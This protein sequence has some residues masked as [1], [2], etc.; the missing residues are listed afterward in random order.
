MWVILLLQC[1]QLLQSPWLIPIHLL[2][3][4][5]AKGIV[6]ICRQGAA[7]FIPVVEQL[8]HLFTPRDGRG[9][10]RAI[11][12]IGNRKVTTANLAKASEVNSLQGT[13]RGGGGKE[14]GK[15]PRT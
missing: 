12:S 8:R 7:G 5:V 2:S 15:R 3:W 1:P 9:I 11:G 4:L 10:Q 6:H 13:P 14:G